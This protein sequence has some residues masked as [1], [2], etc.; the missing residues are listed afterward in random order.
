MI[1]SQEAALLKAKEEFQ[2]IEESIRQ[3]T[4]QGKRID[5]FEENL[6]DHMLS[7]GRLM[8]TSFVA[9]QG[10]GDLGPTLEYEGR[11]F[12]RLDQL[13]S[14]PYVSVFGALSP[15][16]R[17]VY[18]TRETQKHEVIPLDARLGLPERDYS[19]LLQQWSQSFCVKGSYKD[20]RTYL[21]QM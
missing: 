1:M 6:W 21:E 17:V 15:I 16:E 5:V 11:I 19:Y 8:L 20:A 9:G 18:G 3:A 12:R 4:V 14:K 10:T 13:H 7:L 2:K